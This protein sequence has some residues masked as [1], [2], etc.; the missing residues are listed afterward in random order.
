MAFEL[1]AWNL[2]LIAARE[3]LVSELNFQI[4]DKLVERGIKLA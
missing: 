1:M 4:G 2:D 3:R